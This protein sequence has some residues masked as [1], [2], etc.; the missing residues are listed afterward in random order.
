[1]TSDRT[2]NRH[3]H[4]LFTNDWATNDLNTNATTNGTSKVITLRQEQSTTG[5]SKVLA[6]IR[7]KAFT[8]VDQVLITVNVNGMLTLI[9]CN[10]LT[11]RVTNATGSGKTVTGNFVTDATTSYNGVTTDLVLYATNGT[12]SLT[13]DLILPATTSTKV[14]SGNLIVHAATSTEVYPF[15]VIFQT[16]T[17]TKVVAFYVIRVSAT[18]H[19]VVPNDLYLVHFPFDV[20]RYNLATTSR[21]ITYYN[22]HVRFPREGWWDCP[23]ACDGHHLARDDRGVNTLRFADLLNG[24]EGSGVALFHPIPGSLVSLVRDASQGSSFAFGL[25]VFARVCYCGCVA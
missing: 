12:N 18:S 24:F 22:G 16:T 9:V 10:R 4:N 5:N 15:N 13:D 6:S 2:V 17:S 8:L 19:K 23:W 3:S 11:H 25:S 1:M 20:F 21:F 7:G 14:F